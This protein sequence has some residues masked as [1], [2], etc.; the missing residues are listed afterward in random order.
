MEK[1]RYGRTDE[2]LSII[3]FGGIVVMDTE[4]P[5][6]SRLV[7]EAIQRGVNYFDVAPSYGNAEACL[8]PALEPYRKEVFLACKTGK[9]DK[10]GAEAELHSSLKLLRTDHF[11]LYQ[12]HGMTTQEDLDK[13]L[14]PGGALEAFVEARK[15]GLVRYLG[16]SAHSA[17]VALTLMDQ[18]EFDSVLFPINWVNYFEADFGPQV[19]ARAAEKGV[20]RLALKAMAH[21]RMAP[22]ASKRYVKCW[23]EP[24]DDPG[25]AS[26]ALRFT[27]SQPITSAIP[28][29][30]QRLF[31]MAL[32]LAE[33]FTPITDEEIQWLRDKAKGNTPLFRLAAA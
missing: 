30:D 33:K 7:G 24:V 32:D 9:R 28:P 16:F 21:S 18:F 3:G 26:L 31:E 29:G 12:L 25:L 11:D 6:A 1:R 20:G 23:Y 27:L 8:G 19:V 17:E 14:A 13:A 5:E 22:G 10:V 15:K 2:M 4:P